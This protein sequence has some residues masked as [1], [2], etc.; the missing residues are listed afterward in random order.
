[1]K[2]T[3]KFCSVLQFPVSQTISKEKSFGEKEIQGFLVK[4]KL[5]STS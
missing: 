5:E 4:A 2:G 1:M 3:Q